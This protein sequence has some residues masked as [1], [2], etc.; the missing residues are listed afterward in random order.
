MRTLF[1]ALW[2][3]F[4]MVLTAS[5][6]TDPSS[7][8]P[9][10]FTIGST[11]EAA[12]FSACGPLATN[13]SDT[14]IEVTP[15]QAGRLASIVYNAQP[16]TTILLADGNY[17][18]STLNFHNPRV[19]L[20]SESGN[21][22]NVILDGQ[23]STGEIIYIEATNVTIADLTVKRA[24]YHAIHVVGGGHHAMLYNLHIIDAKEQFVKVNPSGGDYTDDGTLACSELE[25]T[26]NGRSYIEA[27]PT[28][29]F[30]CYTGGLDAHQSRDWTVRDNTIEN[31]YCT[32]GGLAEHAIHFWNSSRNPM[33]ERNTILNNARGI[34]F[35]LG[36]N[37][38]QRIYP[39]NPLAGTGL[40]ADEVQHI[41]GV[42]RNNFIFANT[43]EFD[44]G[45][46]LEQAWGVDIYHNTVYSTQGGLGIDIR[47]GNS[48]PV[49]K[50][51]LTNPNISLRNG[52]SM[53]QSAANMSA[54]PGLFLDLPNGD[55]HLISTAIQAINKGA[56]LGGEV[57]TDIDGDYRDAYPDAGAD[58]YTSHRPADPVNLRIKR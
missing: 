38:G 40:S 11:V 15:G 13:P 2:V 26:D 31:I 46:G 27:N 52:G 16:D 20:R 47:F 24:Y 17:P 35:G 23:Y 30:L 8:N 34:G 56:G 36:T 41:G 3:I 9:Y 12:S 6:A 44:T 19:T 49:V 32:D 1:K 29:G 4:L 14:I 33:V 50:N 5:M 58:E 10:R 53:A 54:S 37:G 18:T 55:L 21:R 42:I 22:E 25:L 28:P 57:P 7:P 45:I 43:F 51:N 39:D 48:N